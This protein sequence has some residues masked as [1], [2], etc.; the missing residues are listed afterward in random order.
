MN[1]HRICLLIGILLFG[2]IT[3]YAQDTPI[4]R[5]ARITVYKAV[6][7]DTI[8]TTG[9]I[10]DN[11][12][13]VKYDNEGRM[14]V[15]NLLAPDRSP[16]HKIIYR[17]DADGKV[18][19]EIYV[20]TK[21]EGLLCYV[22]GYGY[23]AE[24]RLS[25]IT[26]MNGRQDTI[27]IVT[28]IYDTDGKVQ[29]KIFDDRRASEARVVELDD[30]T[31]LKRESLNYMKSWRKAKRPMQKIVEKDEYGNWTQRTGFAL[32]GHPTYITKRSIIYEG[33]ESDWE[34]LALQDKVKSVRQYSY[35]AV[36]MGVETVLRGKKQG[37]FFAYE[38]DAQ[39][40]IISDEAF[41]EKGVSVK[42]VKYE[43]GENG[44]LQKEEHRTPAGALTK[45]IE[46]QYGD[47]GYCKSGAIYNEKSEQTGKVVFRHDWEGNRM[48]ETVYEKDG[49][50]SE[51]Y[52]YFYDS[53]G[54]RIGRKVITSS[55]ENVYPYRRTWN[56]RQRMTS[57]EILLPEDKLDRYTYQY[58]KKG[59][60][61][62]GTEQ[63]AGQ[64]EEKFV[65]KFHR[66]EKGN[67]K[68]RIKYVDDI[69]VLYE[70]RKYVYYEK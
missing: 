45:Y 47:E 4:I 67:W 18:V 14:S 44:K 65:Y 54:Q 43:Y 55:T 66:D 52:R 69:P 13:F 40:R 26:T 51:D 27:G 5:S 57:E 19:K 6:Q 29:K 23:D 46:Y 61:I 39:G 59:E 9:N 60:V 20:G 30:T 34:R 64:P 25:T 62:S 32:D 35:I 33:M 49:T 17:Y 42:T 41:T 53:Y 1:F 48:Q 63:P 56:F 68:I 21:R 36:P 28:A 22:W 7:K 50:K 12:Y 24:G 37:H 15:E 10:V 38:F 70:E 11:I 2:F 58:N 31:K 3:T 8:W 16:L